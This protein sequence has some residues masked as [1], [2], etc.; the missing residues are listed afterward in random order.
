[1]NLLIEKYWKSIGIGIAIL[2]RISIG[3]GIANTLISKYW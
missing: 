3:I 2:L 1:M